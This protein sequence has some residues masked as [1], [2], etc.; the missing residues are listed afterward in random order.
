MGYC[1]G[2][3]PAMIRITR[4]TD[5]G[6]VL[7]TH[8]ATR[9]IDEVHTAKDA[10][11]W[12]GLS[13]PMVS[14]IL[15]TL[16]RG[17]LLVSH[18]GVKGGYGLARTAD[19]ITVGDVIHALEGPIRITE[20]SHGP[21]FCEQ[22][23]GCPTRVNWQRINNVVRDAL[24]GIPLTEMVTPGPGPLVQVGSPEGLRAL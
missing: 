24:E 22:E 8:M 20:C 18:R 7:L 6:I 11:R 12:S 10:A 15:K 17:G 13:L 19:K 1:F 5:Y 4:Q 2:G 9:P 3:S 23:T 16:A 14:K 21:G